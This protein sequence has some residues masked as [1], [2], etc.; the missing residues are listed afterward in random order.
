M[1]MVHPRHEE[2]SEPDGG[3]ARPARADRVLRPG[4]LAD[5]HGGGK[6]DAEGNHEQHGGRLQGNLVRGELPSCQGSPLT[7]AAAA[8]TPNSRQKGARYRG[9]NRDQPTQQRLI[10]APAAAK[11][12]ILLE[13]GALGGDQKGCNAH[14]DADERRCNARAQQLKTR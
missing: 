2:G 4:G 10:R 7:S 14:A 11:H 5:A 3:K 6:G 13:R 1:M 9:P 8:K 12:A